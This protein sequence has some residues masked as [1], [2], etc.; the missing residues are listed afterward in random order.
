MRNS[1]SGRCVRTFRQGSHAEAIR[2]VQTSVQDRLIAGAASAAVLALFGYLLLLGLTVRMTPREER[3][4]V[5]VTLRAPHP[6]PPPKARAHPIRNRAPSGAASPRNLRSKMTQVVAPPPLVLLPAPPPIIAAPKPG[7]GADASAGA[8]DLPGPGEGAGGQG[9]GTG[10][11]DEG[12]GEGNGDRPPR[13]IAGRL[14]ASDLPADLLERS[15]KGTVTES[16]V[17]VS[18][19]VGTDGRVSGCRVTASSGSAELDQLTCRLIETRFRFR[20]GRDEDGRPFPST[21]VENH[22]WIIDT[23]EGNATTPGGNR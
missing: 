4:L 23:T 15:P 14:K 6:K 21:I 5:L 22:K 13:Q 1:A 10:R 2:I 9:T 12:N 20:P 17:S 3:P 19:A 11:G 7:S 18:Y 16:N 8:S